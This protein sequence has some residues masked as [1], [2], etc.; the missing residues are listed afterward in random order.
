[1]FLTCSF[2][3]ILTASF[4][5]RICHLLP[6]LHIFISN[7]IFQ[8]KVVKWLKLQVE[9]IGVKYTCALKMIQWHGKT[10]NVEESAFANHIPVSYK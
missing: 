8:L 10:H 4:Y 5:Y 3:K 7:L 2:D 6:N 1:M 9:I